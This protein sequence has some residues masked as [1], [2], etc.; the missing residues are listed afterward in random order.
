M[1]TANAM[2]PSSAGPSNPGSSSPAAGIPHVQERVVIRPYPK[3][4]VYYPTMLAALVCG[5]VSCFH[6]NDKTLNEVVGAAFIAV[7]FLNTIVLAFEFPRMTALA[8]VLLVFSVVLSAILLNRYLGLVGF[9]SALLA[10]VH[11]QANA[12]FYL[13][14]AAIF[15]FVFGV[16]WVITRF[17]YWEVL[18]NE[19]LHHH[20]PFGD[21]ERFPAPQLK[22]DKEIPD[23]F[24]YLVL[25]SG[26]LILYPTSERR[27][28]ILENVM[29]VNQVERQIKELL[30]TL[31]VRID[32]D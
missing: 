1:S 32:Q 10:H 24:E 25:R 27:A 30:G 21:L 29:R 26:R 14:I 7:L 5:L 17:D 16:A 19:L 15:L 18:H 28:L 13:F 20:G 6:S 23:I 12:Q 4:I 8:V 2:Q 3:I 31:E 9:L 11:L 22:L